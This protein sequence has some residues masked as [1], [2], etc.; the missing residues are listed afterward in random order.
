MKFDLE[1]VFKHLVN[2]KEVNHILLTKSLHS[3]FAMNSN[4]NK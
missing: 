4:P 3:D 1:T 2:D